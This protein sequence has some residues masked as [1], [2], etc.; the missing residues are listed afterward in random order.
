[1]HKP[2]A[3]LFITDDRPGHRSQLAGL[4]LALQRCAGTQAIWL[5]SGGPLNV[6]DDCCPKLVVAA[7]R[8]TQWPALKLKWKFSIPAVVLMRPTLPR[9]LFDCCVVPEHDGLAASASIIVTKG[10]LNAVAT[11]NTMQPEQGLI[12]LGGVSKH[13]DCDSKQLLTELKK[14]CQLMPEINW[15]LTTSPRTP[16]ELAVELEAL[17]L[18]N[19]KLVPYQQT[20]AIWLAK[21]YQMSA[22]I[23]VTEDSMSMVYEALSTGAKVGLLRMPAKR[24]TRLT[25]AMETLRSSG[26]LVQTI[27]GLQAGKKWPRPKPLQEANRV[28]QIIAQQFLV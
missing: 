5:T 9:F 4:S 17:A 14:L 24:S 10:A 11:S 15:T 28:A 19:V 12:L 1:M 7:G 21:H 6:P 16:S 23:W 2:P 3:I 25:C 18:E 22:V 8:H 27:E 26:T 20:D 13:F